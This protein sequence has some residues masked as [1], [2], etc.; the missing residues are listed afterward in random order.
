MGGDIACMCI[1]TW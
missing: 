1:H